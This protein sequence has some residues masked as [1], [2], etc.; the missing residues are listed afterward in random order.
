MG[1]LKRGLRFTLRDIFVFVTILACLSAI[2]SSWNL[3]RRTRLIAAYIATINDNP[4]EKW[5][6]DTPSVRGLMAIGDPA[7]ESCLECF[8][9]SADEQTRLRCLI[10]ISKLV[11][12]SLPQPEPP[13]DNTDKEFDAYRERETEYY[14]E[15]A[16]VWKSLGE[17]EP[18]M[19]EGERREFVER[20]KTWYQ[21]HR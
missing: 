7:L 17:P 13:R 6:W 4:P 9:S 12:M 11:D 21:L 14:A 15:A 19:P 10:V 20:C 8:A 2:V 3:W 16:R 1:N 18:S 5:G